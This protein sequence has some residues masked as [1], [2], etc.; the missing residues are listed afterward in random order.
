MSTRTYARKPGLV[1]KVIFGV[2]GGLLLFAGIALL[3]LPGPG[4]LLVLAGLVVL[5]SVFPSV[6]RFVAPVRTRAVKAMEESV[7][8]PLRLV[9]SIS[10]GLVLIGA[11][12]VWGLWPNLP[13]GGWT[14]GM[15]LILSG[16][17]LL[18]L[19]LISYRRVTQGRRGPSTAA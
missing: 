2:A 14:T 10:T 12:V 3:I 19:L 18:A 6:Q 5:A 11:G 4:L 1:R 13:L 8:S 9:F 17:I 7:A 15:S 16:L